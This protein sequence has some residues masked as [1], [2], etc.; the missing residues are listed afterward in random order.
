MENLAIS[1]RV[2][3]TIMNASDIKVLGFLACFLMM[4][5]LYEV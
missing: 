3:L 5:K 1:R 4:S 2:K